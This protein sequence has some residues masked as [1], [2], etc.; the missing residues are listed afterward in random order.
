MIASRGISIRVFC[1][2]ISSFRVRILEYIVYPS[3]TLTSEKRRK[4]RHDKRTDE[5]RQPD[6][7]KRPVSRTDTS[8]KIE[9]HIFTTSFCCSQS[10]S[11][12][13]TDV[14]LRAPTTKVRNTHGR[15]AAIR[16]AVTGSITGYSRN[17]Y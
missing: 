4:N 11:G 9:S 3:L 8:S 5:H 2:V 7:H 6:R 12:P 13:K 17:T 10:L 16:T 14:T 1:S 15:P